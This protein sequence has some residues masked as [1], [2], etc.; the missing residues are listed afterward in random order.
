M[1]E[2]ELIIGEDGTPRIGG[3]LHIGTLDSDEVALVLD[4]AAAE[5]ATQRVALTWKFRQGTFSHETSTWSGSYFELTLRRSDD[6]AWDSGQEFLELIASKVSE[7]LGVLVPVSPPFVR[8]YR[9]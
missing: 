9:C 5:L 6:G 1:S 7:T 4:A 2:I 3:A 8:V